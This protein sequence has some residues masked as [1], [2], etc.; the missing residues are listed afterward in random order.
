ML[1]LLIT[2]L[3][4]GGTGAILQG[5]LGIGTGIIIVP[6]LTLILPQYGIEQNMAIHVAIATSMT[7]IAIS[8]ISA[9]LSHHK[10]QNIN[11]SIFRRI[12]LFSM[13]GSCLGAL[14]ASHLPSHLLK[15]IF[16]TFL[17]LVAIYMLLK[18]QPSEKDTDDSSIPL[19]KLATGGVSIGIIAS[20]IGSGGGILMVPF[21]HSLQLK[22]RYAVGTATLIGFPVAAIGSLTYIITGLL[23]MPS[24]TNTI[25]YLHWP[26]FLMIAVAGLLCAPLGVKLSSKLHTKLLQRLFAFLIVFIGI[27]M[28]ISI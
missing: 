17:C 4:A 8:S 22:M 27:R 1:T 21:L 25:G 11:W 16:G 7:A 2:C 6:I 10:Y 14:G 18:K 28:I 9:L 20:I 3:I 26:S 13:L 15:A 24:N 19:P 23:K 12:I 5:M